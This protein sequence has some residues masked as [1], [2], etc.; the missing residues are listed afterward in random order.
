MEGGKGAGEKKGT[1]NVVLQIS[2]NEERT[3]YINEIRDSN[4][5]MTMLQSPRVPDSAS[6]KILKPSPLLLLGKP[7]KIP[8]EPTSR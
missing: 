6:P 7:F 4:L 8:T 1:N 2:G 5:Q 3:R